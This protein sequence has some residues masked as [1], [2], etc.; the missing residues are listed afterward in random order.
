MMYGDLKSTS[1]P[2][3]FSQNGEIHLVV[4]NL[5]HVY[6][7]QKLATLSTTLKCLSKPRWI[8]GEKQFFNVIANLLHVNMQQI[9]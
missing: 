2:C 6:M 5:L 1:K 4:P 3:E 8:L 9:F 7:Q